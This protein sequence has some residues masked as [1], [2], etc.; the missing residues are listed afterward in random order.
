MKEELAHTVPLTPDMLAL[1]DQLPRFTGGDCLFSVSDGSKP[2]SAAADMKNKLDEAMTA[3]LAERGLSL[4]PFRAH[5]I[6][7]AV[8][9]K[10]GALGVPG[11]IGE[12]IL[13]HVPSALRRT[14]DLHVYDREK[15]QALEKWHHELRCILGGTDNVVMFRA[16]N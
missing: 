5:D 6:R 10:L 1:L 15:R 2:A 13:A 8:R 16:A 7:R 11:E 12:L 14:Y 3:E 9:T 4:R